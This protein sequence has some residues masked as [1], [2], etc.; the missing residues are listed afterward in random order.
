MYLQLISN[1]SDANFSTTNNM[2]Y[3]N[4]LKLIYVANNII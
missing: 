1:V 2:H 3:L 4:Y